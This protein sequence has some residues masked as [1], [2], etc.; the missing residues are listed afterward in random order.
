[1]LFELWP[2]VSFLII[3]QHLAIIYP[4]SPNP[5]IFLI[6]LALSILLGAHF[7]FLHSFLIQIPFS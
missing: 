2:P 1:M 3:P 6:L 4:L 5:P 7:K